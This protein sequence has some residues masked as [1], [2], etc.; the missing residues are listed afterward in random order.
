MLE[1]NGPPRCGVGQGEI[2]DTI[3]LAVVTRQP[4]FGPLQLEFNEALGGDRAI[5]TGTG[6]KRPVPVRLAAPYVPATR[7]HNHLPPVPVGIST[8][9]FRRRPR[10][11]W[12]TAEE[13]SV[14]ADGI[15]RVEPAP[16]RPRHATRR[17][18]RR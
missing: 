15:S 2:S 12:A 13:L 6:L 18:R 5:F 7:H 3:G 1:F 17:P 16:E 14:S 10:P 9:R 11:G 8:D 4:R